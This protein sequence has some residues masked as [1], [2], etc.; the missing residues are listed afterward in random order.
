MNKVKC[1]IEPPTE[2]AKYSFLKKLKVVAKAGAKVIIAG[3]EGLVSAG[4]VGAAVLA[5][6]KVAESALEKQD[7][8][9]ELA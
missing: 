7:K 1:E 5:A 8:E 2:S 3:V 4:P 9:P 6:A